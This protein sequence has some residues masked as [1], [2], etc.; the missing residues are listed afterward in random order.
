[1]CRG[2]GHGWSLGQDSSVSSY[3]E[4]LLR[5]LTCL[6]HRQ[7]DPLVANEPEHLQF[8]F[9]DL[10]PWAVSLVVENIDPEAR[11]ATLAARC[12]LLRVPQQPPPNVL[13]PAAGVFR[14]VP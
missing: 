9:L 10:A 1:M 4:I 8:F 5:I 13:F 2:Q 14:G 3:L 12:R 7:E 11:Y 6:A